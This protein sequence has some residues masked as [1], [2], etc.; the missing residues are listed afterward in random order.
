MVFKIFKSKSDGLKE[1][2]EKD[3]SKPFRDEKEMQTFVEKNVE[4]IFSGMEFVH[5]EFPLEDLR[6]DTVCFNKETNSFVIIEYKND[7]HGGVIDQGMAYLDLLEKN[8]EAFVLLYQKQKNVLLE[9]VNWEETK[10]III[11]PEYTPHQLR[12]SFRTKDPIEL[13]KIKGFHDETYTLEKIHSKEKEKRQK[14]Y[15]QE[16]ITL[17]DD[18][19][20]NYLAGKYEAPI[21][22][23]ETKQL[24]FKLKEAIL[25]K[26]PDVEPKQRKQ[27]AGFYLIESGDSIC[28][29]E[30]QKTQLRL[31]YCTSKKDILPEIDFIKYMRHPDGKRI[32]HF[33]IGDFESV[34]TT[35]ADIEKALPLIE[36]IYELK[37]K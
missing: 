12:A 11:A 2:K 31:D 32:G 20:E 27:Y 25:E 10:I 26:F 35:E 23:E 8:R 29:I 9:D 6:I 15:K 1:I 5:T 17:G 14:P 4:T 22:S 13:W 18:A 3:E 30:A 28:T 36:K 7:K 34:I 21:V 16:A 37:T 19:E 24:F 33:G